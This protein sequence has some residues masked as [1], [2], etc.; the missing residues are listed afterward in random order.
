M[1]AHLGQVMNNKIQ[2]SQTL[3]AI[4]EVLRAKAKYL[5]MITAHSTSKWVG[6]PPKPPLWPDPW[7]GPYPHPTRGPN[8]LPL[9]E[10][11]RVPVTCF[12]TFML[13]PNK[14]LPEF[15]IW[16]HQFLLTKES[17]NPGQ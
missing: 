9:R 13:S 6:R 11:A 4:S 14:S 10:E 16:S 3:T 12:H 2:K 17:K 7:I 5:N 15:L 1:P 8:L